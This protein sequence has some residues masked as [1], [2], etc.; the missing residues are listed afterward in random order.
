MKEEIR[1][2]ILSYGAD[3]CGFANIDRF[4]DAP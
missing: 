2:I 3:L 4:Q 1:E